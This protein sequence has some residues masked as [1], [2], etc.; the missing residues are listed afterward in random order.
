MENTMF[1]FLNTLRPNLYSIRTKWG[2]IPT[3][4]TDRDYLPVDVKRK[5]IVK[6]CNTFGISNE[7]GELVYNKWLKTKPVY[8]R[9]KNS[10]NESVLVA[11]V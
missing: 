10:T 5:D 9:M 4:Y 7:D 3:Y 6:L 8:T 11:V 2:D 1:R